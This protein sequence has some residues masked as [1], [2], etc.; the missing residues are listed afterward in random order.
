MD[1]GRPEAA[2][3]GREA[4]LSTGGRLVLAVRSLT[5]ATP[6]NLPYDANGTL[7]NPNGFGTVAKVRPPR[8]IQ[9]AVRLQL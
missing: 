7:V 4:P 2:G 6:T 3:G 9:L 1:R 5:D 8:T